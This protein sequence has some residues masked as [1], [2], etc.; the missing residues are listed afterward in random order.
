MQRTLSFALTALLLAVFVAGCDTFARRARQRAD[1]FATLSPEAREK[2]K[3]GVIEVGD[4]PDMVYIALGEPNEKRETADRR[5][6]QEVWIYNSYYRDYAGTANAGYRRLLVFDAKT[7]RYFV[8][9]EPVF[10]DVYA[11]NSEERIRIEFENG[12]V[13][14]IEQPKSA[15]AK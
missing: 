12:K 10:T 4:T 1:T 3:K 11:V 5:K 6:H 9:Y 8:Y 14:A 2:L 13:V 15:A 7:K